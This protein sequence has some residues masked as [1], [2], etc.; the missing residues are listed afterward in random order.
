[1]SEEKPEIVAEGLD[2]FTMRVHRMVVQPFKQAPN[3][4]SRLPLVTIEARYDRDAMGQ[5]IWQPV[6]DPLTYVRVMAQCMLLDPFVNE[7]AH[8]S[9]T[10][11]LVD[12]VIAAGRDVLPK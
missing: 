7:A 6:T 4:I 10:V 1:M 5:Y 3:Q 11:A 12:A 9:E 2:A 8:G